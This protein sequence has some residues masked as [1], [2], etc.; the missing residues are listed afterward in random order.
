[1][2][3]ENVQRIRD[4]VD[5]VNRADAEA[6]VETLHPD[7]EWEAG[8]DRFPG[9]RSIYRGRAEVREWFEQALEPWDSFH[10]DVEEITEVNDDLYLLGLLMS[11]RGK[12]SGVETDLRMWQLLW[13][14]DGKLTRRT[15]PYLSRA[16]ALEA[17]GLRESAMSNKNVA[18][19]REQFE[20]TNRRDFAR[21]MADWADDIEVVETR[22]GDIRSGTYAGREAVA[23]FFGAWFRAFRAVQF[24]LLEIREGG[25]SVAVAARHRAQG[26]YSG[27][28][29]T[30]DF[31]YE[32]RLRGGKIVRITIHQTWSDALEAVG[33]RE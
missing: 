8:G 31:F 16:E 32:Y 10:N 9:F 12:T 27:I 6:F 2:S 3:Q 5:A 14:T 13:V 28:D 19:V 1:M 23:E 21:P 20:A 33:L 15:G 24:E 22:E 17:V 4:G 7:V 11:T 30:E 18:I 26:K 29:A 25:D